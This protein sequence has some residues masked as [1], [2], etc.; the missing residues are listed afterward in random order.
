MERR[1]FL[2]GIGVSAIGGSA[3]VGSGAFSRVESQR[4][5][6]IEVAEDPDAYLGLSRTGSTN[7]DNYVEIDEKGH[8]GIDVGEN[9]NDG[10]GVNSDSFTW[11][12]SLFQVCNQGKETVGFYIEPPTD[13]DY[14]EGIDATGV[15]DTS[16]EDEP[17]VQFYTGEAAGVGDDGTESIMGED[18]AVSIPVGE[19]IEIGLR[20]MTKSVDATENNR[21]FGDELVLTADVDVEGVVPEVGELVL[22]EES[23]GLGPNADNKGQDRPY[24]EW[25]I[26]GN[27]IELT[28]DNPTD[29]YFAFDYRVDGESGTEDQWTGDTISEGPLEGEDFGER[30]QGVTLGPGES[31]SRTVSAFSS[32]EVILRRG[33]EQNWYIPWITFNVQ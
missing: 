31:E 1:K 4:D 24:V 28:F 8:L 12:D 25:E 22:D 3:L 15:E 9:P 33:A 21:L 14:P 19:C 6:A 32:V 26:D 17:R 27:E 30:Y 18:N 13:E 2:Y 20:T 16:Y 23:D 7:S 11:F 10:E 5:V 29:W